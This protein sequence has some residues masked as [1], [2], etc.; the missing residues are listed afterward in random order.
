MTDFNV[1][2]DFYREF[3]DYAIPG[4]ATQAIS[5]GTRN[6]GP[7]VLKDVR[8]V[9]EIDDADGVM[10]LDRL[11]GVPETHGDLM[12][13]AMRRMP[14]IGPRSVGIKR[15]KSDTVLTITFGK[16]QIGESDTCE[17]FRIG[18][19]KSSSVELKGR[20]YAD[21]LPPQA[22]TLK[23]EGDITFEPV[24]NEEF[25]DKADAWIDRQNS[26]HDDDN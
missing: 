6:D 23:V 26:K 3:A 20:L 13:R 1:N 10:L 22:V 9:F 18:L 4:L 24:N 8:L 25:L 14:S 11:P 15:R 17:P 7:K 19:T 2:R 12:R 16:M 5:M 21:E